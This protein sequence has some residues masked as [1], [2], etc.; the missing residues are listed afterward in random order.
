MNSVREKFSPEEIKLFNKE[1]VNGT[2]TLIFLLERNQTNA[3][4]TSLFEKN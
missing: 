4:C 1:C 2:H 3:K